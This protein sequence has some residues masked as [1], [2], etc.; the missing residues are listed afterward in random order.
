MGFGDNEHRGEHARSQDTTL[1]G[2]DLDGDLDGSTLRVHHRADHLDPTVEDPTRG[3]FNGYPRALPYQD[4]PDILL[5]DADPCEER[6]KVRHRA[7]HLV[8]RYHVPQFNLPDGDYALYRRQDLGIAQAQ[9]SL[10]Q[11]C[12]CPVQLGFGV[13]KPLVARQLSLEHLLFTFEVPQRV[14]VGHLHLRHLEP[15]G[16]RVEPRDHLALPHLV[17]LLLQGRHDLAR[18]PGPY[19]D[20]L[21]GFQRGVGQDVI[22]NILASNGVHLNGHCGR[23]LPATRPT[24]A[25]LCV[26]LRT[27]ITT[28]GYKEYC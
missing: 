20:P 24:S 22:R 15:D 23:A 4:L 6:V 19:V 2:R 16:C 27:V 25:P 17:S 1:I 11:L 5:R 18:R 3:R 8:A 14:A 28:G 12:P 13:L 26:G 7:E 21:E 10:I 9:L